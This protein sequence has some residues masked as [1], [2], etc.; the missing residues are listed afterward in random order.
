MI[1]FRSL[2][3]VLCGLLILA[4]SGCAS[5]RS[6]DVT[7]QANDPSVVAVFGNEV[8]RLSEFERQYSRSVSGATLGSEYNAEQ[9]EDFLERYVN[10]RLKVRAAEQIG[11]PDLPDLAEEI[12]TY[13]VNL[14]RPYLLEREVLEPLIRQLYERRQEMVDASHIL[15]RIDP[16]APPSDTLD[17]YSRLAAMV[18]SVNAGQPFGMIARR[19]S[20]DPS[21]QAPDGTPGSE[22]RLG[23]FTGGRMVPEF[24]DMA[25]TTPVGQMSPIFRTQFG[26]HVLKVNDRK[27]SIRDIRVAHIMIRPEVI[28]S[29]ESA[30][31][32]ADS[33]Y[34]LIRGGAEFAAIARDNS[35]D[36][37][38]APNGGDL[39]FI[40]FEMPIVASFK[41]AAFSLENEGDMTSPVQS[42][43]GFHIIRLTE[44]APER[45]FEESYNDLKTTIGRTQ[46]AREAEEAFARNAR[47]Q[48][49]ANVDEAALLRLQES[50][51]VDSVYQSFVRGTVLDESL[52][53]QPFAEMGGHTFSLSEL[54][55]F[56]T[57]SAGVVDRPTAARQLSESFLND[58]AIE[59]EAG[60][61]EERDV[62]FKNLMAEFRDGLVLFR[63]M[64]DSV[65]TAASA[66]T[67]ALQRFHAERAETYRF[68]DR[69]RIIAIYAA[70]DT[71][72]RD[73]LSAIDAGTSLAD[74]AEILGA[75]NTQLRVDTTFVAGPT[76]SIFDRALTLTEGERTERFRDQRR[77]VVLIHA[78]NDAA[79]VKS[80]EEARAEVINDYQE[81]LEKRMM[82][83]LRREFNVRTFPERLEQAF[84]GANRTNTPTA[85]AR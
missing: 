82:D 6:S 29:D 53:S 14:A 25:F 51:A 40:S 63:L 3:P 75:D 52:A 76:N 65:W 13:R 27:P 54:A 57:R 48:L 28:G 34:Q 7:R 56:A 41:D 67:L 79:R 60:R 35:M 37:S 45:S 85:S 42:P 19:Y 16:N 20:E 10:F 81:V 24:E 4:V 59:Q 17:A 69:T 50:L 68:P 2:S 36:P 55:R 72:M 43:Y 15:I 61:L 8:L 33:L 49:G 23:F 84:R 9:F 78:G 38:T 83:R 44:L 21:A 70:A 12:Q 31:A 47:E 18:D 62:D 74:L 11:I 1:R 46:R 22:G 80:F 66:D 32:Y 26:Y 73:A 5:S 64:E 58:R 71:L 39:G 30:R 77:H